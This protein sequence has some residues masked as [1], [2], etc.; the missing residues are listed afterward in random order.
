MSW[1][2]PSSFPRD[3]RCI[4]ASASSHK[5]VPRGDDPLPTALSRLTVSARTS[6]TNTADVLQTA[7]NHVKGHRWQSD[8]SAEVPT[9]PIFPNCFAGGGNN[10]HV[11]GMARR[12]RFVHS[13]LKDA[14][15]RYPADASQIY[16]RVKPD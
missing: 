6:A 8:G 7:S 13:A 12:L 2:R 9:T 5:L 3:D 11:E 16:R 10:A 14:S 4:Y 15:F 1:A